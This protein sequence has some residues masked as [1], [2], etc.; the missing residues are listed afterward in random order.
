MMCN[1]E[2]NEGD[3]VMGTLKD[4]KFYAKKCNVNDNFNK[5]FYYLLAGGMRK[6]GFD[7]KIDVTSWGEDSKPC[8]FRMIEN[9]K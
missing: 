8:G 5:T 6:L 9:G 4:G 7:Y 3:V 1:I 2:M